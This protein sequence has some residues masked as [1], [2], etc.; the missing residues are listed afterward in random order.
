M[1]ASM[2]EKIGLA[3]LLATVIMANFYYWR[4]RLHMTDEERRAEDEN[5]DNRW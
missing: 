3:A 1:V 2:I 5:P 4:E